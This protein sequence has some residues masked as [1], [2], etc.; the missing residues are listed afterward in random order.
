[1]FGCATSCLLPDDKKSRIQYMEM[2]SI[3]PKAYVEKFDS[4]SV[5]HLR[6]RSGNISS[7][8]TVKEKMAAENKKK[9]REF[10]LRRRLDNERALCVKRPA[11]MHHAASN[12]LLPRAR[13]KETLTK[14]LMDSIKFPVGTTQVDGK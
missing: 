6:S 9:T 14:T 5:C 2:C 12:P 8:G 10:F 1:M 11:P 7:S 4:V 3:C 13:K